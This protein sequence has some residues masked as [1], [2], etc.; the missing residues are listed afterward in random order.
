MRGRSEIRISNTE[1]RNKAHEFNKE[2]Q[3]PVIGFELLI[4]MGTWHNKHTSNYRSESETA[5]PCYELNT[6]RFER[7][8]GDCDGTK[9]RS[10]EN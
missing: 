1:I 7:S 8:H 5:L 10:L 2:V 4:I 3:R 9:E 6:A